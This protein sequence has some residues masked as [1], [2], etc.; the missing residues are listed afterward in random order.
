[1]NYIK[2]I[3][4]DAPIDKVFTFCASPDGFEKH[5]PY[6]IKWIHTEENWDLGSIIEFKFH[7]LSIWLY[8]KAEITQYQQNKYFVD[9][10]HSNF[11]YKYFRHSHLFKSQGEQTIYTDKIEF[12]L[13]LGNFIDK[14][15]GIPVLQST[16]NQRHINL[17]N[18][19]NTI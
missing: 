6:S 9:V 18:Y 16:F 14:V 1:M 19:F 15:V 12:S 7:Y 10:S 13:G 4:I 5:F 8:W 2:T 3:Q 17:K 11:P